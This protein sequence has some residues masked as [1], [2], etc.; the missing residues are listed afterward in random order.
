[1]QSRQSDN[2]HYSLRCLQCGAEHD[3]R[4]TCTF[5]TKCSGQLEV[6]FNYE[7]LTQ[8]LNFHLLKSSPI[9]A[10][11]Y[12]PFF[13]IGDYSKIVTLSE[14]NT[15]MFRAAKLGKML[16]IRN[17]YIKNEAVN[18]TGCFKDRGSMV[19]LTKALEL[20][21]KAVCVASTGNMAASVSAYSARAGLPCYV[22]VPDGTPTAKLSQSL[23]YG[24]R[25]IMVRGSY[26]DTSRLAAQVSREKGFYLAGDY[27]F[28]FEG[29]KSIAF[30]AAEQLGW[31]A[32]D[33]VFYPL[34]C[35]TNAAAGIKGF[36][37]FFELGLIEG[38]PQL[39]GV[40]P[41]KADTM[42]S[43]FNAGEKTYRYVE[44]PASVASAVSIDRPL[45][46]FRAFRAMGQ[47]RGRG[48]LLDDASSLEAVKTLAKAESVF[49]EPSSAMVLG[50][51]S[52]SLGEG[53]TDADETVLLVLTGSGLKDTKGILTVL[54]SP[55]SVNPEASAVM[56][57]L[58]YAYYDI[59]AEPAVSA[60]AFT[61]LPSKSELGVF[62]RKSFGLELD[63]DDLEKVGAMI[64]QFL[65]K[66]KTVTGSDMKYILSTIMRE[67]GK[68]TKTLEVID[69]TVSTGKNVQPEA[70]VIVRYSDKKHEAGAIGV[71]P[72]DAVLRAIRE[73]IPADAFKCSLDD[74]R[75]NIDTG[76]SNAAV[77]V[78]MEMRTQKNTVTAEAASPDI[79][80]A[81]IR[82]FED[83][84]NRLY[85]LENRKKSE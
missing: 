16:G 77:Q 24:S 67:G 73:A 55:P 7:G 59:H 22:F 10:I 25:V 1:M 66:G 2:N 29:Q 68:S 54:P 69:F 84:F 14:G 46:W 47:S 49:V 36:S 31:H 38:L 13:P 60:A 48:M 83:G 30:E 57:F 51:L 4:E 61:A 78:S 43:A 19:E 45:D 74:Y 79:I 39:I 76:G 80:V 6:A 44:N 32:P 58:D 50:A 35:G 9:S 17:L 42:V 27:A 8:K 52:K 15:G 28:R 11:K 85:E 63:K 82:A 26:G 71:G 18:P 34:G 3:E 70:R 56:R 81:S 41:E 23:A 20:G 5:C 62:L 75:V 72:V 12:L 21:A 40:Q 37:E 53:S 64:D 33:K 65:A